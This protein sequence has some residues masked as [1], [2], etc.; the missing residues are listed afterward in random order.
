VKAMSTVDQFRI[1]ERPNYVVQDD[2]EVVFRVAYKSHIP[3]ILKGPTGCGKTRFIEYMAYELGLPLVTV[4]CHEDLTAADLVGRFL[5]KDNETVWQDGPLTLAVRHGGICYLD[6]IVEARKDTTVIIHSLTDDRRILYIDKTDE[7]VRAH[8]NFMMVLSYNLGYQSIVK[9]LKQ[10][11]KQRFASI[12]FTHPPEEI[13]TRIIHTESGLGEEDSRILADIVAGVALRREGVIDPRHD[14]FNVENRQPLAAH[15]RAYIEHCRHKGLNDHHVGEKVRNL[16][17]LLEESGAARLSELTG[18]VV[19]HHMQ[20]LRDR[21]LSASSANHCREHASAFMA[22]CVRTGRTESNPVAHVAKL[23]ATRDRRHVRRTLAGDELARLFA[24]AAER[25]RLAWYATAYYAGLRRGDLERIKW[26]DIDFDAESITISEGKAKRTD[27]LPLHPELADI[28]RARKAEHPALP[29]AKVFP[30]SVTNRTQQKDYLRAGLAREEVV[31]DAS[32][33]PVMIGKGRRARHKTRIVTEDAEGRV[34]DL[35][36]LR[37]TLATD[38]ARAGE[39]PQ[40]VQR[41]MR[42]SDYRTT[43]MHYTVLGLKDSQSAIE[44]L[45]EVK[46]ARRQAATGTHGQ[47]QLVCQQLEHET[48]QDGAGRCGELASGTVVAVSGGGSHSLGLGA[49]MCDT[50][51]CNTIEKDGS[52]GLQGK[53]SEQSEEIPICLNY[54]E[55]R[56]GHQACR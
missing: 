35:H 17:R 33:E 10:S 50:M 1:Q 7:V 44:N 2:E 36:A 43:L 47:C 28:L 29:I 40:V 49:D 5:F 46:Q 41:I 39:A 26:A 9:D 6:E 14:R 8:R 15:V 52:G 45:P 55:L 53:S 31:T 32:G 56:N 51:Q 3:I 48:A 37:V 34:V 54:S 30:H 27:V 16:D 20:A 19:E 4:S 18:E 42:H 21:G 11:T 13:E 25:G 12:N 23:D 38:L 24:V 22:W